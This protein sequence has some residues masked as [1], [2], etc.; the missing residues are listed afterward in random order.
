MIAPVL[1][2][3]TDAGPAPAVLRT[4]AR[5][6]AVGA[7]SLDVARLGLKMEV[8]LLATP[9]DVPAPSSE[10]VGTASFVV[11]LLVVARTLR[12]E[13][14]DPRYNNFAPVLLDRL[15]IRI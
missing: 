6:L 1:D 2:V 15:G 12:R 9:A 4:F 13:P 7:N 8:L 3:L 5:E 10:G 14:V 11:L